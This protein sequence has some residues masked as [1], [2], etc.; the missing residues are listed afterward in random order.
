MQANAGMVRLPVAILN[1]GNTVKFTE[2]FSTPH[3]QTSRPKAHF[4]T[5]L[6]LIVCGVNWHLLTI[7]SPRRRARS[8]RA[9]R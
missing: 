4:P 9:E 7:R 6:K 2:Y 8:V 5:P 1:H 3:P